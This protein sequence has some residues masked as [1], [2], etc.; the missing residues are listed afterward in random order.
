MRTIIA[1]SRDLGMIDLLNA[2]GTCPFMPTVVICGGAR[3]ID[4]WGS[5]WAGNHKIPVELYPADWN[6]YGKSAGYRRNQLRASKAEALIA[7][8][9]GYSKGTKHMIDIAKEKGLI[10]HIYKAPKL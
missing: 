7:V 9:D 8:W 10:I 3:G 6:M 1:G 5:V 2:I 4:T